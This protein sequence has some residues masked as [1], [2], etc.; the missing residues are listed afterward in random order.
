MAAEGMESLTGGGKE[1]RLNSEIRTKVNFTSPGEGR[2]YIFFPGNT[3][4][5]DRNKCRC[6]DGREK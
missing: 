3:A 1:A 4:V 6:Q 2:L 5:K